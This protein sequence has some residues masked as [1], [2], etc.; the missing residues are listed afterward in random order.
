MGCDLAFDV[1]QLHEDDVV[2][3]IW[4]QMSLTSIFSYVQLPK[5]YNEPAVLCHSHQAFLISINCLSRL[6]TMCSG[7]FT[8]SW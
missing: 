4:M 2:A 3:G 6:C 1:S 7:D 5:R 8:A